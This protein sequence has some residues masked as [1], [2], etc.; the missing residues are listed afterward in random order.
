MPVRPLKDKDKYYPGSP[1]GDK[2]PEEGVITSFQGLQGPIVERPTAAGHAMILPQDAMKHVDAYMEYRQLVGDSDGGRLLDE[3][4]Y[5]E[6]REKA[7]D[8]S[9]RLW[10]FWVEDSG[11]ECKAVGPASSCFC[12]HRYREHS[13]ADYPETKKL[14]CK[15]P[16]CSCQAYSYVPVKGS[17]DLKCSTCRQSYLDHDPKSKRCLRGKGSFTSSYSCSCHS[18]YDRH[19]TVVQTQQERE[20]LGK[21]TGTPWMHQAAAEHLP[22]AHMGGV[23]GFTALADGIDRALAGLEP[24]FEPQIVHE[25]PPKQPKARPRLRDRTAQAGEDIVRGSRP[26]SQAASS[27]A[28]PSSGATARASGGR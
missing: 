11:L 1:W 23:G 17:G 22:T 28:R 19:R 7:C 21:A 2:P 4:E 8:V 24:G 16:G 10:V 6:L 25:M 27:Q 18:S 14:R 9:R 3:R 15:M 5:E 20:L 26:S 13:W 12:G